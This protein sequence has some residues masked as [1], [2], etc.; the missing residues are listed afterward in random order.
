MRTLVV[1]VIER[2]WLNVSTENA[3]TL[4][5]RDTIMMAV[6]PPPNPYLNEAR[7]RERIAERDQSI[8][9]FSRKSALIGIAIV[10]IVVIGGLILLYTLH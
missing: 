8:Q 10:L 4:L 3:E 7:M 9:K 2:K 6:P 1:Y 5:Q